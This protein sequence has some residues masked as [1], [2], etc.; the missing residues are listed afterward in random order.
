MRWTEEVLDSIPVCN[1]AEK[2]FWFTDNSLPDIEYETLEEF[3]FLFA[4][5]TKKTCGETELFSEQRLA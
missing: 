1:T 2:L 4:L 3:F 5:G